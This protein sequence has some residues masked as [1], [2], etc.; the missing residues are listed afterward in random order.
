[1]PE[2]FGKSNEGGGDVNGADKDEGDTNPTTTKKKKKASLLKTIARIRYRIMVYVLVAFVAVV[3]AVATA[4][5][6]VVG[7]IFRRHGSTVELKRAP[8]TSLLALFQPPVSSCPFGAYVAHCV[9]W[10]DTA[11]P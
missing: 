5:F 3:A 2:S 11:V 4:G 7:D 1:M 10:D 6:V 9:V 8:R